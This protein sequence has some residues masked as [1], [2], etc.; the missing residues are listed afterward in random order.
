MKKLLQTMWLIICAVVR[1][2]RQETLKQK[3]KE[4]VS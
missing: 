3:Q 2:G 4:N 1:N